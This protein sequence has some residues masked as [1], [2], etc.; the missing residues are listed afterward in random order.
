MQAR[1]VEYAIIA[2]F[3]MTVAAQT[4]PTDPVRH[5]AQSV[6]HLHDTMLDPASFVL[7]GVYVTKPIHRFADK[8]HRDQSTY[9]YAFRSHNAMGGYSEARAYEDP[10]DHGKLVVV[11]PSEDGA[12]M[13][14]DTG[15]V[16]PCKSNN[17]AEDITAQVAAVAPTLY[18]KSR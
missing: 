16:A 5:A 17:V 6:A 11:H 8:D 18:Q 12:F 9:C 2:A 10:L 1:K 4:A 13:G 7:D 14:Y 3:A 15:W